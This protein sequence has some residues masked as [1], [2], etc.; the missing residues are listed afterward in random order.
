MQPGQHYVF[1]TRDCKLS[2]GLIIPGERSIRR[3]LGYLKVEGTEFAELEHE[4]GAQY[5]VPLST[6]ASVEPAFL[7]ASQQE[8]PLNSLTDHVASVAGGGTTS[9]AAQE[10]AKQAITDIHEQ[11]PA[12]VLFA[13]KVLTIHRGECCDPG[14]IDGGTLQE[15]A[16]ECGLLEQ[17]EVTTRC[18]D[19]CACHPGDYCYRLTPAGAALVNQADEA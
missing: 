9:A 2:T 13:A 11:N 6:I 10:I 4:S 3:F 19:S 18:C 7:Q 17:F 1:Q 5:L 8:V 12:A 14:D 16:I 15:L